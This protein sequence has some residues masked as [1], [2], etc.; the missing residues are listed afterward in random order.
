MKGRQLPQDDNADQAG[1]RGEE[2][3]KNC[4]SGLRE[5]RHGKLIADVWN[6][7]RADAYAD[8]S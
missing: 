8:P 3:K 6:D 2:G 4:K 1:G 5:S 7:R